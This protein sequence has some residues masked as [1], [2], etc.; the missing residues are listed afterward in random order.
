VKEFIYRE[1]VEL[2]GKLSGLPE[3][4]LE[5]LERLVAAPQLVGRE[6]PGGRVS[7][8]VERVKP[9][10]RLRKTRRRSRRRAAAR[11]GAPAALRMTVSRGVG[12]EAAALGGVD[13]RG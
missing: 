13:G 5:R 11:G 6:Q 3:L 12:P 7:V 9:R 10:L 2:L 1:A 8:R 4:V